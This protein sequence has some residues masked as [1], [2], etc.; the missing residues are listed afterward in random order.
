MSVVSVKNPVFITGINIEAYRSDL[1][2]RALLFK[3][4]MVPQGKRRSAEEINTRFEELKPYLLGALFSTLSKA[5]RVKKEKSLK[6]EFRMSDFGVW[7]AA[8]AEVVGYGA[9]YFEDA[10]QVS[11]R[12]RAYEA[13]YSSSVGRMVLELMNDCVEFTGTMT[14]L[15]RD[16]KKLP[17]SSWG[18]EGS[19]DSQEVV[20][21][22]PA[23]LGRKLREL[24]N[25]LSEVGIIVDFGRRS[26][27]ERIITI[28]RVEKDSFHKAYDRMTV[29][30]GDS[31]F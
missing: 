23:S 20:A 10:L 11:I 26:S 28:R 31:T 16:L 24:E 4:E 25:S 17:G 15:L 3:T 30:T 29:M 5:I 2:S 1:L 22:N 8:C 6:S 14:E 9:E 19:Y 7:G 18:D 12:D 27:S 21:H 13:I